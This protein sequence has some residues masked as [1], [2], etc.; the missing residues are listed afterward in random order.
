MLYLENLKASVVI[1]RKLIEEYNQHTV[2]HLTLDPLKETLKSF[3]QKVRL[4]KN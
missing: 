1:L 3:K 2:K 4:I